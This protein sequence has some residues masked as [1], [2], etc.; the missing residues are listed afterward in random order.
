MSHFHVNIFVILLIIILLVTSY[1]ID[2]TIVNTIDNNIDNDIVDNNIN[3][4]IVNTI[5]YLLPF[6]WSIQGRGMTGVDSHPIPPTYPFKGLNKVLFFFRGR[7]FFELNIF[8]LKSNAKYESFLSN[9]E[10][11]HQYIWCIFNSLVE[12]I[13]SYY[14]LFLEIRA[15]SRQIHCIFCRSSQKFVS[16][17]KGL[18]ILKAISTY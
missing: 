1:L 9:F 4:N 14:P 7:N 5:N 15:L 8:K 11:L 17:W 10:C 13:T 2:N 6:Q 12:I 3:N 16:S 18:S